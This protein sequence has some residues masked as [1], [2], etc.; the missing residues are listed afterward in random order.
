MVV[1]PLW[2]GPQ[3]SPLALGF[4]VLAAER[5][6][7]V[8]T[9]EGYR[10]QGNMSDVKE[11]VGDV[12]RRDGTRILATLIRLLGDFD[13]AEDALHAAL[14]AALE[15]W[16]RDGVP[17]NPRAWLVTVGRFKAIDTIRREARLFASLREV[18]Q[19]ASEDSDLFPDYDESSV[20][21]DRLRLIFACCHPSLPLESQVALTLRDVCGLATE[22][23]AK[24]YL[25]STPT[26]A[27]RIVRAKAKLRD[28]Q[29]PFEIPPPDELSERIQGVLQVIYLLFSEG[30]YATSGESLVRHVLSSEAIRLGRVLLE[31]LPRPEVQGLLGLM[32]LNE[33]RRS[34]RV[35]SEGDIV[36]L[37]D[38]DQSRWDMAL[39]R[40]GLM[41][42]AEAMTL[43]PC[44]PY[45]LQAAIAAAHI[46]GALKGETNWPRIVDLYDLLLAD[47]PSP[48]IELNR[49]AAISMRD[50]P[51]AGLSLVESLLVRGEL[52]QYG[53]AYSA[54]ADCCRRLGRYDEARTAYSQALDCTTQ[55]AERRFLES[56]RSEVSQY[57]EIKDDNLHESSSNVSIQPTDVDH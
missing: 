25:V 13:L 7:A 46:E 56:R 14:S 43:L 29:V 3:R 44:D 50:G 23:V 55:A 22:D 18:A 27:Q 45:V 5:W 17:G 47:N 35:S 48:V 30:Y 24:A 52:S 20:E 37:P 26:I 32:L 6:Q 39:V 54:K 28:D 41:L 49:A 53:L 4:P 16:P 11:L 51:L 8:R 9:L 38:Q 33:S 34:A 15:Q 1:R 57:L 12:Y 42:C 21:D 19:R 36:L 31:L 40:E 10:F 2:L